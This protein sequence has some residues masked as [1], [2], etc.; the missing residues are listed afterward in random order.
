MKVQKTIEV[1][2]DPKSDTKQS[3]WSEKQ[4]YEAV[5]LYKTTGNMAAVS[6][7]LGIPTNTLFVWRKS[8]WW[9]Q[10]EEDLLLEKRALTGNRLEKLAKL[11][12]EQTED[13]LINGDWV[14]IDGKLERKPVQ[15]I[16]ANKI[17]QDSLIAQVKLEEHY[18]SKQ[19]VENEL[20]IQERLKMVMDQMVDFAKLGGLRKGGDPN[21]PVIDGELVEEKDAVHEKR[22]EG[23]QT[24]AG[25]GEEGNREGTAG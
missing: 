10:F 22:E 9:P 1:N 25:M 15:A 24:G 12:A 20:Q 3:Q 6:R 14:V 4:K 16:H 5:V 19:K 11:A 17:L 7:V 23:L 18:D 21:L 8:K 2:K 13:R